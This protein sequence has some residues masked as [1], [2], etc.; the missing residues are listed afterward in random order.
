MSDGLEG[1]VAAE[2]V[3]SDV[4]GAGRPADHP[5]PLARRSGR[6]T[7]RFEDAVDAAVRR[8]LRRPAGT[9]WPRPARRGARRGLRRR[10]PPSTRR[11][12]A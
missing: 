9:I 11:C 8:L 3:L 1:V 12:S 6:P 10:S 4:D 7:S 5:R 2:T